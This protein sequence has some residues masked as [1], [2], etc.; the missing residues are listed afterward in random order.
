MASL[1]I[2]KLDSRTKRRLRIR[3]AR[4]GVSME[5]EARRILDIA[6]GAEEIPAGQMGS[7]IRAIFKPIGGVELER[8]PPDPVRDSPDFC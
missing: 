7:R 4:R 1:F 8:L 5:A 6:V 2:R 3:A